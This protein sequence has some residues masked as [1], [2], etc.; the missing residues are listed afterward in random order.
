MSLDTTQ[1]SSTQI[2]LRPVTKDNWRDVIKITVAEAQYEFVGRPDYYLTMCAYGELWRPL[3]VYLGEEVI[4]FLMWAVDPADGSCWLGGIMI[5]W[6]YQ[7]RGFGR[8][9]IKT[10]VNMLAQQYGHKDFALSYNPNNTLAK[11]LY[12][13]LGFVETAEWED[14][15]IVARMRLEGLYSV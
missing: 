1:D 6:R 3:A 14:D 13:S 11:Q 15:E 9:A 7:G 4:G 2:T 12:H 5:D 10:A 8:K